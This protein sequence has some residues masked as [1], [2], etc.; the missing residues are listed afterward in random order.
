MKSEIFDFFLKKVEQMQQKYHIISSNYEEI[1]SHLSLKSSEISQ[2]SEKVLKELQSQ[3]KCDIM[4]LELNYKRLL[5]AQSSSFKR[6]EGEIHQIFSFLS[7]NLEK[8]FKFYLNDLE[9]TN[10]NFQELKQNRLNLQAKHLFSL[11]ELDRNLIESIEKIENI[12]KNL[13]LKLKTLRK[14]EEIEGIR[15]PKAENPLN[16]LCNS[17]N[18]SVLDRKRLIKLKEI[19]VKN[20]IESKGNQQEFKEIYK[21][22]EFKEDSDSEEISVFLA[23]QL[24]NFQEE[25]R[26]N[27]SMP[28]DEGKWDPA[29]ESEKSENPAEYSDVRKAFEVF[30]SLNFFEAVI[31]YFFLRISKGVFN[32]KI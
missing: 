4:R 3:Y 2:N 7:K 6:K 14:S 21:I 31:F 32:R 29:L 18:S 27:I 25:S 26:L 12:Q 15:F 10:I 5:E 24:I 9:E 11:D 28:K 1:F 8:T 16:F 19:L 20:Q 30:D 13:P 23:N 17:N 22:K